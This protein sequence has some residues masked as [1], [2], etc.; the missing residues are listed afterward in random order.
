[1]QCGFYSHLL[2]HNKY[3]ID[4]KKRKL[5]SYQVNQFVYFEKKNQNCPSKMVTVCTKFREIALVV[6]NIM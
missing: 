2:A 3:Q 5:R 6:N 1:M 4:L